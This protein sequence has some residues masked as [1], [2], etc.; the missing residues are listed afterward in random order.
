MDFILTLI[1]RYNIPFVGY[2]DNDYKFIDLALER[3]FTKEQIILYIFLNKY[4][5]YSR[6]MQYTKEEF[7]KLVNE[8]IKDY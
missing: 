5:Y 8:E 3:G 4:I 6:D 7:S 1:S 2:L